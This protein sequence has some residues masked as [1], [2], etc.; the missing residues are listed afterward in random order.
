MAAHRLGNSTSVVILFEGQKVPHYV[1]YGGFVT[2][3][4]LYRQHW[5]VCKICG[6][7]GHRK[8]VCPTPNA[9]VCFAC[10]RKNPGED[11]KEYCKPN[12]PTNTIH[13]GP[14]DADLVPLRDEVVRRLVV[15]PLPTNTDP[16]RDLGRRAARALALARQYK[17]DANA[18]FVDAAKCRGKRDAF[19]T[20]AIRASTGELLT[21]Q[22]WSA[23]GRQAERRRLQELA[24]NIGNRNEEAD[25]T[26]RELA[27]CRAVAEA[28]SD[29]SEQDHKEE[30]DAEPITDYCETGEE[31]DG[32]LK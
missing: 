8:D 31:V 22:H 11:H 21:C 32:E 2:K 20:V 16:E 17:E 1:Q 15:Y 4:T 28:P 14:G 19:T 29:P 23:P 10:G 18:I 6:Q 9:R 25:A 27:K 24:T 13:N 12:E 5:E 7:V 30:E 3:C 26:A